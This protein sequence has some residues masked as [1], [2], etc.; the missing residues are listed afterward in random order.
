MRI[1]LSALLVVLTQTIGAQTDVPG[2][3][4][5]I[6]CNFDPAA[7]IND[8]TCDFVSCL[9]LGCTDAAACNYN[10]AATVNDGSC[11]YLSCLVPGC[12][13][14]NACNFDPLAEVNDGSCEYTSCAGCTNE[15]ADN[16]D[17]TATVD[18]GSCNPIEGCTSPQACNFDAN[19]NQDDGSCDFVSCLATGCTV[20]EA[21][22]YD[23]EAQVNDGTCVFPEEGRDCDGNCLEDADGDN[24][25]DGDEIAG[26]TSATALNYNPIATDDDGSCQ[27]PIGGCT[28][29]E[30]CNFDAAATNDD[31]SCEFTSCAGCLQTSACNYDET[32]LYADDSCIFPEFGY[33]CDGNCLMDEDGDGVCDPFE[34]V[35]CQ[36]MAACNFDPAA[37]DP[38]Q[39]NFAAPN[40]DCDGNSLK[41]IFTSF[42][43]NVTVQGWQVPAA[44]DA[45]V[46]AIASPFAP[47]FEATYNGNLCYDDMPTP[48]ITFDGET[49]I[50]GVCEHDYTLFRSWTA[51]DCSGYTRSREQ[52][53]VVVDTVPPVVY[54]PEDLTVLCEDFAT[55]DLGEA[56]GTDDCGDV[57]IEMTEEIVPGDCPGNYSVV[58]TFN[59]MDPCLNTAT[60]QQ[61]ITVVDN[62]APVLET[63]ADMVLSCSD[64]L[65][66]ALPAA[67][68][69]CSG[70]E[71]TVT[72]VV[73]EGSCPQSYSIDRTFTATDACG[74]AST[75]T[76]KLNI[77]DDTAPTVLSGWNGC[78]V[79]S[80]CAIDINGLE[81]ETLPEANLAVSDDCDDNPTYEVNDVVLSTT[82]SLE[83]ILREFLI[84]DACGN[85]LTLQEQYNVTLV[86]PGCT[87]EAACNYDAD[88]N[89]LDD[90]CDFC[91]CGQNACGCTDE[92]ACNY[93]EDAIYDDGACEYA[94]PGFDCDG[95]CFDVNDNDI[96]DFDEAG[97]TDAQACNYDPVA[98]VD[99][100][101]CDYCCAYE[102][103]TSTEAGYS[104]SIDLVQTHTSG[105]LAGLSTYRVYINTPNT[106]DV[107]T[108]VTGS[109]EFPLALHTTTSFYQNVFG[110]CLGTNISPAMMVVAPD[111]AYDSWV[112]I[113][114]TSSDDL[115][116]G[117]AQLIPG[118]WIDSFEAGNSIT[119]DDN[120]GSGWFLIPPGGP[121]GVSGDDQ[122]VLVAQLTTDGQISGSFRAQIFPQG[123]QVNDVRPDFTFEQQPLGA[124]AC[125]IIEQGPADAVASCDAVPGLPSADAFVVSYSNADAS[126]FGCDEGLSVS[127]VSD[128]I[129][130]GACAGDYTILRT[131]S[132]ENCA[133]GSAEYAYTIQVEDN[134]APEITSIPADYTVECS[135]DIVLSNEATATD[136]CGTVSI[137][138]AEETIA[139]NA[140]GNYT[141]LR[142]FTAT[143]DCGNSAST[144]QT[145]TVE[146]TTAPEFTF[147][148]ADYT[149]EC[150]DDL[151][152][153]EAT[154][155]D[156]C[157]GAVLEVTS[158][159]IPGNATG[160]YTVVRTFTA[161]DDAGNMASATQTITV[162]DTT[163]PEFTSVPADYTAEC[164]DDLVLENATASDNCNGAVISVESETIEGDAVGNYT[165]VRTFTATDDAGNSSSATQTITVQD[166]TAPELTV[167]ADYTAECTDELTFAD[168]SATDNCGTVT[169]ALSEETI[170]GDCA[171]TFTLVRTFTATDDAGNSTSATQTITVVDTTAPELSI[172][173]DYTAE[174]T[175]DLFM[176]DATATDNCTVCSDA[177]NFTSTVDGYGLSLELV[178]S[179]E[180]GELDGMRTY[181]V[182]LDVAHS[183]DQVTSFTGNDEF[184]LALNTTTSFYQ[185]AFG[186][187]TSNDITSGAVALVPELA[188]DSYV[189]IGLTGQ[190]EGQ[191]GSVELIPGTWMDA[192]E[193]GDSFTVN[194]GIGSGWYIIPP[195]AVNGLGGDDQRVLVAQL[196]TDGDLSGQFRTQIFPQGD[197]VNDVRADLTF[198]HSHD[199][200]DVAIEVS[201]ETIAGDCAGNYTIERTFT[202]TDD[203][204]NST[205]AT[206]T[207]TVEDTTA[208]EFTSVPADYT[209][210]CSDAL[211]LDDASASDNCGTVS[212]EVSSETIDGDAAGNYTVVRT[213]T[214]TDD[215]GN[216]TSATQTITVQDTTAPEFTSVPADY[217]AECSD[218]LI[219]DAASASDNCGEVTIE[220]V[221]ETIAGDCAGNY[222]ITRTFTAT[223]DAGNS[224][225][226]TQTITV[227]DTTAPEFTSVPADYTAECSDELILDD[228]S[229]SDNCGTV[230]IEVSSETID[231]DAAGNYTVVRTFTATDDCGNSTSATQTITVQDTTA[232]ELTIPADYTA[233]CSDELVMDAATASDNCGEVTI[234]EVSE[235]IAG[236]CAGNYTITRTFT[237]TDDAGNSTSATQT[238]TVQDTT[239]PE[240]TSVPAD[241][242]AECS[243][244]LIL[245]DASA[246]DN[247]GTVSIEVSS[248]TIDGDAAGNYTVV[249]TF[250]ATDDCGNST[251]ATQT[252]TVQ[253]TTAPEFTSVPADYTA[254]CSDELIMDAASASDNC[255]EVTIEEVSETIA[256]DCAGNYTITRTFTAT[257]DAGNS[258]S[259]TQTIT[260]Q[261][262]TAPEFTSVP[263]DYTA[264]CSDALILDDASASDN[265]GT[266][267]IEVSSETIGWCDAAGNYT[268]VRTFT[269]TDD[270]GNSTSA[271]Q[272]ITVQ[273]TTAPELTI[274]ADYTAEC[275]DEL[276]MDA[277]TAS[278]NC[279][280]VTIE[281][282][283]E[284]I[285]GD[286]AGN[287]TI[288]RTFTATDDAGNS[289][290]ATQTITVQ[291]TTAPELSIPAD[292]TAECSDEL[293]LDDAMASDNCGTVSIEVSSETIDGDAAGNYTVVRTFTATDDCGNSTSATQTITVQDT[294]APELTIPADYTAECSDEL[295]MDAATASDNCGEVAIEE[296]SETIEG[297]CVGNY[298]ITRTFTA[299]DDAGNST[300]ATQTI[301]VQDTTAPELTIPADYTAECSDELILEEATA[302]D[303]CTTCNDSFDFTSTVEGYGLSLELVASHEEGDLAGMRTY[304]IYLDVASSDDQVTSFTGND[305]FALSL[306]TT[307]SFYQNPLGGSTPNDISDAAIALVPELAYDSYVTVGLTGQP[308]GAEGSV[309]LIPGSWMD[310]FE[311]GG[312]FTVNDGIG[313]GW[314]IVPPVA[315]NGLGG[316]DQRVLVAQ[317]TTD[318]D[319]SGQFRTQVFP[320][321][322]QTNDVR[323][324]MTFAHSHDC[325]DL[326]LEVSSETIAGD[327]AGNYTIE[328]TFTATDACGNSTSATQ[329]ITVQDTTAPE[330]TIPA[331]YTAECSDELVLD[332]ATASDNCGEVTIEQVSETTAGDCAGNYTI[333]RTFTATDDCG[334]ST[335]ATQ[336][337]T[338]E[339]TTAPEFTS[340]PADYTAECSD[341]LILDDATASDNCGSVSIEVSSETLA[342]DAAGNYTVVRTFTATD[343]CGNSTSATQTITVEDTT[344]PELTI[345][346]D[347]TAE[348]SDELVM[349][350]ATASDNCGE[351]TIEEVS[352]TIAGD[353][354][355][356]YTITRTFT[357]TDDAGN[358]TSATQ[359]ITVQDT[360]AP[361]F[362]SVP[363]DY[364]AE[365]SDALILDDASASDN[366]GTV[367]IEVSSETLAGDAAGNYTVVRT[368]TATDDC[369]NSTS[370]T[371]TIT[372]QDTTAPEFTSVPADYTAECSDELIMDAASASDNCGEVTIEEVS[373]TIAGDCAG[374]YTITRTFTATDDA[375]NSTSATQTITVQDTTAPEF[376]SVPADYTAECS[377]ALILDDA[378]ASDNCGTVS[379]EV[380]SETIDGDAAGNYTVVRTFTATD[381][382]GNSTSATQTITV[383]DTT[384]PELT[385]PADYTA[386]CSDELVMDAATAS[387]NCGEVTIEEVSETI[388]GD[389]AG[390]YTI[391][392]TFT[393]TD[394]AGN[395][396]SA[397][398]TITVQD[399]TAPEFTSVPADYTAECSDELILDDASASDN[400]GT[401]SIEVSSETIDG[402]AAGNYTVV[403]TFTA[404]D[405]CGN[406]TSATQT[407]T[408]QDTT[409]PEL[410]IPADYTAECSDELV[411]DAA[412]ASD[413][414]GEVTIEEVSET[415]AGD[416]A[417]NYTIT[418]TFTATDDAGNSTSATQTI[419]VQDTTAPEFTS[420]P[421]DYTAECSD[422]LIL[423][424]ASASDNCG[425]VS[426]E[427]SSE[428][429]D[430]DAAGNYTVVRTFTATDDCGNS[431][432]AT[433]TIT[434]QD[435]TA[436]ELT[437]PADYTAECSDELVM[438]A[439]TASDNCGEVTIEEVSETI[440]GDCA[441]NYTITRTF[442]A[443]DDAGNS[444]SAT[445][446]ITVQDTTAPELSIPADY[447]A[448]CSDELI[449]DDATATDNCTSCN[450]NFDFTSTAEGY[451]LSLE[452]VDDH[453]EGVLAGM[454]TYR[455]YLEV[456]N[457]NDQVTSFTGNDEF[458][459]ALNT[460]TSFYQNALGG[461]TPN[462]ISDAAIALVPELAYDSY[463]T[464]GLTGEPEGA[465][466]N[467]ELIPGDWVDAFE[468]GDSFTVNDG[469]GSG[470]YIVPPVAVNG[471]GG[472]DQRVLVAQ[473]TTDGD[474]SGQFRTQVFPE[475]DQINDVRADL[476]FTHSR[477]CEGLTIEVSSE[478]IAGDCAGS[479]TIE[480]TFTA[481]DACGNSSS[482][483]Q[484][485]TVQD[486]TAPEFTSVPADYTA[487]CSDAL[488]LDDASAS[489]NCGTVS[490]EVSS[491]TIDGDAA[492]NYTVVRTFTA[493]D[494]CGNSTSATQTITVQDTTAPELTIPA[495]YTAEC[496]DELVMDA[497]TASDNC[498]EVTIE[499]VSE[500]IAGDCAGNYTITRTFTATDDAGNSTS[501]TQIITVQDTTA[502]EFTSVP[503]DYTA[504]CSDE[505]MLD[506]ASASDNCGTVSIEVSSETIDGDAAGNYTVVRTFTATDDCG[507]STSAT[508]TITVQDTTAPE[509]T[510][511][512]ADYTAECSDE[513]IMDAASASDNCGEVT[514]EEVSE[515]I[516]GDCAGNYTITRTFTAT[517][518]AGNSTSATQT[519]TV[520]DTTAPEFTSVPAD[521]TA[522]CSDELILDDASASDNCGTVSIEVSSETIDGDAAGNYTV[523]RT[524][525]AMDDCGNSTSATQTITVEDTTAPEFTSVPADYTA[526]CSDELVMDA[527][528][529]SDNCGEVTIEEV[530][531]T[532]AGDCAGN[533]TITRTFT[534]TDD[535]G[536][537]TSATQTI[538][539]Q[540][541]TAPEFT[542]VPADYTA[543]C[544]DALILDD[545]TA[546][547]N[548]GTVSIEV[549]SETIDGDAAGNYTVV[550]TF[551]ATDDC[552]N[553]TSATQTITVE[554]TTA[555]ELTI[556]ADYTA[557]CSDELVMDAA[558]AS[559]NCGEVT[560]EEV[561]ET[562]A[563]DCA[564]NYTITRTF[565]AT[566]DAG[567]STSATQ[568]ITVQD[569]T[570]PEFT[571][572]PADYTAECSDALILD[573]ASASDNCGTVSIEV[574]SETIDGDA[575]G[576]YTVVRTF[577]AT[578][579]CGNSTSATQT[580][581]VQDTTAPEFTSVP[582]DYTAE[583]S[584]EL[585][586]DAASASDNCG[587]VTI[588]EASE[589]I[590][591]DCAGNY[592][593][594]RTFT[595][596][597]DAGNS[598]SATQTI[599]VQDTTAPEFT[600]V[601]ADY[602]AECSDELVLDDASA[603][604]NCGTVSIEVS[605]ETIAGDAAGNYTVVRTFT[606]TDDCGNSTSATQ[607]ITVQDTTAPELT[608]PADYTAECSDELVMDAATA[609]DNCGEVTIEEVS[610]TIA[611]D[612]A[613]NYT[614]TRTF[615]ASDDAGNSTSATQTITVEDTTAPEF[616]SVP[617]D[618]TAECSDALILDDASA[619]DN[620]GTVSIEVSSET[621][622]GDAAGNYTV[623]RTFTATDDCGNSTSAT[624]TITVQDTTAP[625]FTSVPADYTAE[626]SD[627]LI[628]DA[629]SASDNCGEVTIEEVSET[630][631]GDCA[632]NYTITRTFTAT[633]DAGNSTSATQTITVQD[634]TAPEFTS[635]P[636]D[637]TAECSD[638]LILDDASASD[639][640]G[641]VSIEVS[642]ETID[643]DAAGNYT[644][645]RTFTATDDCGNSTSA[646]QTITLQDTTAPELTIPEDYTAECSDDLVMDAATAS[647]NC[648]DVTIEE[649]SE[650]IA[651]DCTGNY[652]I[653]RTFTASD[654]AGNSTSAT[655][656]ITVQ[657]TTAPELNIP[658]DYTA[659]CSDAL[660][661]DDATA[662]DNCGTVSIEVSSETIDGDAA[663]NYTVVRTFTAT[664]DC[665][666]ST[667]ATQ[668]ITVQ[669]TTAPELTIPAD[670]TAECSDELVMD[671][672]TASDN[673]GEVTIEEVSETIAGDCAGNYTITRTFTATD[674]AGN[675]TSATQ[676][677]TVEDTTAPEFTSVPADYTAECSDALI[678]D[679]A[680]ASDNCGTVSIEVS[681]ETID[682]DAAGNY[683]VVR[684]FTATDDCGNSTSATQTI[685]VQDTTAPEFTSVPADYTAE[686]SDELIMDAASASDNCGEVTIEE[687]SE[688]IAGDCAGNYTIT[689]TF[690]ATDDAGNS[691]SATQ[692][693][694]VQDTTAPEFTSVPADY[695]AECSDALILDDASASDNCGT[696]SIE[697]SSETIDGDA[698]GNYT[699]VRTF[700]ATDD[701][702]N[703]TSATQTITVQ[704]T[705]APE[706]TIPADYTAECS[707]ELVMDAATASDNCGEV[708]I[709]EVSE[710]IAGDC[711]ARSLRRTTLA[712]TRLRRR[713]SPSKTQR[714]L[715]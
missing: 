463:V 416:C 16:Y 157:N 60:A 468:A 575:A 113:G 225:S 315:V 660:I 353:C 272:S 376:T 368:F 683:T 679:D 672:A 394:D 667:S 565:T 187:A 546:S 69:N 483:T 384:A 197:Q 673:C 410:T 24:V 10:A 18:D 195:V 523:V 668:T 249:R 582:A 233:E 639:N 649:V 604:D 243:D 382:C 484:T 665:G 525:T 211:I 257:D 584:D 247:C 196:T 296:V 499:E 640:C 664:D 482:A 506:D 491:E 635:V 108:A 385:I 232:P 409:A 88:A 83:V 288:T 154:A 281:E 398:Q 538:T 65:P 675:S 283:S 114:A 539:V 654:D 400:C 273:D 305:E 528:S 567:N 686:C 643:G 591:G 703:S 492:G 644:V 149:V 396:T 402:D 518:D 613:G 358:S 524:F 308:E 150:S 124:F 33:D 480:R 448:E 445:Q 364:T 594:T 509:F 437:I 638:E 37:T 349:D 574:S 588:E 371:Q 63:L 611:G 285:A 464:V 406:S 268:V 669:D 350:A 287:Y 190:P 347:Y 292:Y 201:S 387:D 699:V 222:T 127:L 374:N 498:G 68:D 336:T 47:S 118:S 275:S 413:N 586:M 421:A 510:S 435:T 311:A 713:P 695:T 496:S 514:I 214:A 474:L 346:A 280:E 359:T 271:T 360:T 147:V 254:E 486:T 282:V 386:E 693:I 391:T 252:I 549:S 450:D 166:T 223:D 330:L 479:Y 304:R 707:D 185:N 454:S 381:D 132:I 536:N 216:S 455:V 502:P 543:E 144:V 207:I 278:D 136:N 511:V 35:G 269:A 356:N 52:I 517:D 692:T 471:L 123:D 262:T 266:V 163:A 135:G 563:G 170:A 513:L 650:T 424:D 379:I 659:E 388:A 300:S 583:C 515:T 70:V 578:D 175:D 148:P 111:A 475:G 81:G 422:E 141:I 357:A 542:S 55:A 560:I 101:S 277:A 192:F 712:T 366:C 240:F 137:E 227:Q 59:A 66:S 181:R 577:T 230:S 32:A 404:T 566:D 623:V 564:G 362:T 520:E 465:E 411:M 467:V 671:A 624:Q 537:S 102:V 25:C 609:S 310:A 241:Y 630:I 303:N 354:A 205:S 449:L 572:V 270:C 291:D 633:D 17:S 441:G 553:S 4:I 337:I 652:T 597:D 313:S 559:D 710:T 328:R 9:V 153:E 297:D 685:T 372:V 73:T 133:G 49:R 57:T 429:I 541:T 612:C 176:D 96:C 180:G 41:P 380:S 45:V 676:T 700:T 684:T 573:D 267:N 87:D 235:T 674:D 234:E 476:T 314:Y 188:Y 89:V 711:A 115:D 327:C 477:S 561:S 171:G 603:S 206:Q 263:A 636:A 84:S 312:S 191:Q 229:A 246:S 632:G 169:M 487:E 210:E 555:P 46:E 681:S 427:V 321:G 174:C 621:I 34:I 443:T 547:D 444:M 152:L 497:A 412:T 238:I 418:R 248:E 43:A 276:V 605:S 105:D 23:E 198:A 438:D 628:M 489:D 478:E 698:A 343:D 697:V 200:T 309:E 213:F 231:G 7:T 631:A 460:T 401:V 570:A 212:I 596:T 677:I 488:I 161:T 397:T 294:T 121:N 145:I 629:A 74:N 535:A 348:C 20:L 340:V 634:T 318:G 194:D 186:G 714:L 554:D 653:T 552:G 12:T 324:D 470:W 250:T 403:R 436:P 61:V 260:V 428:T 338:V 2:C 646:T 51:T 504:E 173:A 295:V 585:I 590:A 256:G 40:F 545:A 619:S 392:R 335:S 627:E 620:C 226:A 103:Y 370:A 142:T 301:T 22:N 420:V 663:G 702:G 530:S 614:I 253:D 610:E 131:V 556:P 501:A 615:T 399:T 228:A 290:S 75:T 495:D 224:T 696:V 289:T 694:T 50:D 279:G 375:G 442:T 134:D 365:C 678:L 325:G 72:D 86:N 293:I 38:G 259:A 440:A 94:E 284:T 179:H 220:E 218:E 62:E 219:M 651:G 21:C 217:T 408:V 341:A 79:P 126:A 44:E 302:T 67:T 307:T 317:L 466:G 367:S 19:A 581:T 342:G 641:T 395:S 432:S 316:D 417:G 351:V 589:T 485:I 265:C 602:T 709:E 690:T 98:A 383:Q 36:D 146:D 117:E 472:D 369:G 76:Q 39:C 128:Q 534:A 334:N 599:T 390:N 705:T 576:N 568:T 326:T 617:A 708:T 116:G 462:D 215:C 373:E 648:G 106:D 680:S 85:T 407:I 527:A 490:I 306:N 571:S 548:C 78:E 209:A 481:T 151:L 494:D 261:D 433:Q 110:G 28:D 459:L 5:E 244:E 522:E 158:E 140:T 245:D 71:I 202:A 104:I 715:N 601:P 457:A 160:N 616:T 48:T 178:A 378:T 264:E 183:D 647:D 505:L 331:D 607:T 551:T 155:M 129:T 598:T 662:S 15:F 423:D 595:A 446:T 608:I 53:I 461:A 156:N 456:A 512:P 58:R 557:E 80:T 82:A 165:V 661:L 473:L 355:G 77:V 255:G 286:C 439:A 125:P 344:A 587:E 393:A 109:D 508:Q 56:F 323:A 91:S 27:E 691:T 143:D 657:D 251:S 687:A 30:A 682:G 426:I 204:G 130:E 329:S 167:P 8:G 453:E 31:G 704:D 701:C 521:Y 42:P 600:S 579:D 405:D 670:Y 363:A 99:D 164:S 319:L 706:L 592:T 500:T 199:C 162:E 6:A 26:C 377:D 159:V 339:D 168:A 532:I 622:D 177:F 242:T 95:V 688:T 93:D 658:A 469:I 320:Q 526:E 193:A 580:I 431:T 189:T 637:Y 625:E 203:C 529:A 447:T 122:R 14:T 97:C 655:Q 656:T 503:A 544:S 100:G 458:A 54:V 182:Y 414:C 451:G 531:E 90:S 361:E 666:N 533:Y 540:D 120:I 618:Y 606:A 419:T 64:E 452:L 239:A 172:P 332:A 1:F 92:G 645:V 13:L 415:I 139:G 434:V 493:T 107:L 333:T 322:D 425:T 236:D 221:S 642:S 345:P 3:T 184:A 593:I 430:G 507:N 208:P 29:P 274:P 11:D 298:T 569:T 626:C 516:A 119:V 258:R 352:E 112:T 689:R 138:V 562:I 519:I 389:C 299:T 558:T 237:A 550:R